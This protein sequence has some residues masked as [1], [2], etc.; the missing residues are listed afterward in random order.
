[1]GSVNILL[2]ANLFLNKYG[3]GKCTLKFCQLDENSGCLD[4]DNWEF[5]VLHMSKLQKSTKNNMNIPIVHAYTHF[6]VNRDMVCCNYG[7]CQ[8]Y[9]LWISQ[10]NCLQTY[11]EVV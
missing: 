2:I 11:F 8:N 10:T 1:V 3:K 7:H 5:T 4:V 6:V 9:F